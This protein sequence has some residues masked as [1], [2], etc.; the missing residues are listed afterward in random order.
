MTLDFPTLEMCSDQGLMKYETYYKM[1]DLYHQ[2]SSRMGKTI[3]AERLKAERE[4]A[5][6]T[7]MRYLSRDKKSY[8]QKCK[9]CGRALPLGYPFRVCDACFGKE[10]QD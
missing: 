10:E 6:D 4:R 3:D 8:I 2:F 7:I 9:Y 5:E 1:L